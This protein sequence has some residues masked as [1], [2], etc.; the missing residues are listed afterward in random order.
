MSL[1]RFLSA[2]GRGLAH[3][4]PPMGRYRLP[5]G[6]VIPNFAGKNPF[7][8]PKHSPSQSSSPSAT[9]VTAKAALTQAAPP[10]PV[11]SPA[12]PT[13]SSFRPE[14]V[15]VRPSRLANLA[16][17]L[18]ALLAWRP[19]RR[20]SAVRGQK[21]PTVPSGPVQGELR[22]ENVRVVRNDLSDTDYEVVSA[23]TSTASPVRSSGQPKSGSAMAPLGRLAER[24]FGGQS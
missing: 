7:G 22:L 4:A 16:R 9:G 23:Q 21:A 17:W 24:L 13:G 3:G 5:D 10:L 11:D 15:V 20:R 1:I 6:R 19:W 12:K 2:G 14:P 18:K 8:P